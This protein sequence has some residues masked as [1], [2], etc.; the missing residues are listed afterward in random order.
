M[1][2][3]DTKGGY[4]LKSGMLE[5]ARAAWEANLGKEVSRLPRVILKFAWL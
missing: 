3:L 2:G 4:Y 5:T 1:A